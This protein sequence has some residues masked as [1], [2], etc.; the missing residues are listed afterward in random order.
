[1][2]FKINIDKHDF[3]PTPATDEP[4]EAESVDVAELRRRMYERIAQGNA[5][6]HVEEKARRAWRK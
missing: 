5:L 1:M 3:I 6:A 2:Q 4:I